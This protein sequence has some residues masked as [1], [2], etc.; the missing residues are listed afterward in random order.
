MFWQIFTVIVGA[1]R[2]L[3]PRL[4]C[5]VISAGLFWRWSNLTVCMYVCMYV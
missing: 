3:L 5:N 1:R 4:Q 2:D